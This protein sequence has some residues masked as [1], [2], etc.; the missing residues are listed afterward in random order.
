MRIYNFNISVDRVKKFVLFGTVISSLFYFIS[1]F[2]NFKLYI[3]GFWC[4][5]ALAVTNGT[6]WL[7]CKTCNRKKFSKLRFLHNLGFVCLNLILLCNYSIVLIHG[8]HYYSDF[9]Y[10]VEI[11]ALIIIGSIFLGMVYLILHRKF[12]KKVWK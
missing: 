5:I 3:Y 10:T 1:A 12:M 9:V 11:A 7:F 6:I 4:L 8:M 2:V